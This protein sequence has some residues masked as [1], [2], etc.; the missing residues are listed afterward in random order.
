M[1]TNKR[2]GMVI[3]LRKCIGCSAC[4]YACKQEN[5]VPIGKFRTWVKIVERG[6]YPNVMKDSLPIICN[7]CEKPICVTVC[8]VK[9]SYQRKDGIVLIDYDKCIGCGLCMQACPYD[10]RFLHPVQKIVH[11]CTFCIHRLDRGLQPAC[12]ETCMTRA[13]VFGD[14]NDPKSEVSRLVAT[15]PIHVL[16][17][18][19]GTEPQVYY[20][21]SNIIMSEPSIDPKYAEYYHR[22]IKVELGIDAKD[23]EKYYNILKGR[24]NA[25][26]DYD[27]RI[28]NNQ[29][30]RSSIEIVRGKR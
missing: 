13:R 25:D 17:P 14:L 19:A 26:R 1:A 28:E 20:I 7:H 27:H 12:V 24:S 22:D 8:P 11:K 29:P 10:V 30:I 21:S 15:K 5:N 18:E 2:Y 16:K 23:V 3:D 9:A 4:T 6:R